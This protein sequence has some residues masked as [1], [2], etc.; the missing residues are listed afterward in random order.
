MNPLSNVDIGTTLKLSGNLDMH[1]QK[2]TF[3]VIIGMNR[4][5]ILFTPLS[6]GKATG[7]LLRKSNC[8]FLE[9]GLAKFLPSVHKML[10]LDYAN[11]N[12]AIRPKSCFSFE[13]IM[14]EIGED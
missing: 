10:L 9:M 8:P 1:F 13:C 4:K 14:S 6:D 7:L 2:K 12:R 3:P 11:T 5:I